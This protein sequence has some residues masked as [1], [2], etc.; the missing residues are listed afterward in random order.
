MRV[1]PLSG[2]KA[3]V[4]SLPLKLLIVSLLCSLVLPVFCVASQGYLEDVKERA[5]ESEVDRVE[6]AVISAFL[7]GP[8][9]VRIVRV[10]LDHFPE[11]ELMEIGGPE[12]SPDSHSIRYSG[13]SIHITRFLQEVPLRV[14]S[15]DNSPIRICS[16][17]GSLRVEYVDESTDRFALIKEVQ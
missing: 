14:S 9:S 6:E 12:G 3:G 5:I 16:P 7:G 1:T 10:E 13:G 2:D 4:E 17:G 15:I 8:G 11:H